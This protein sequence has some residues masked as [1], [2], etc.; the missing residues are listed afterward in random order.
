MATTINIGKCAAV[1]PHNRTLGSLTCGAQNDAQTSGNYKR[2]VFNSPVY[3]LKIT[4][5]FSAKDTATLRFVFDAPS[6]EFAEVMLQ[7]PAS[8]DLDTE[9]YELFAIDATQL[10]RTVEYSF[11]DG[12]LYLDL[13]AVGSNSVTKTIIEGA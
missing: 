7:S 11:P 8:T 1:T 2:I 4:A 12:L 5:T 6:A 3:T 9:Y 10:T 13:K